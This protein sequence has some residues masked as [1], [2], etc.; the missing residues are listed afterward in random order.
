MIDTDPEGRTVAQIA[1]SGSFFSVS[2]VNCANPLLG[3]QQQ[4]A[5][6]YTRPRAF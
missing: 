3:P 4:A 5:F 6:G 1:P 2:Q